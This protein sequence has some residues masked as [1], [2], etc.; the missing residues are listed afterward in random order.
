MR[1]S[2]GLARVI[3]SVLILPV[4]TDRTHPLALNEAMAKGLVNAKVTYSTLDSARGHT[5]VFMCPGS[6]EFEYLS[7]QTKQFLQELK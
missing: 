5:A 1:M 6:A 3:G 7:T 4:S 2:T